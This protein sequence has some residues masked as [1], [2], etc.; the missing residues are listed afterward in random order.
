MGKKLENL[1]AFDR[2]LRDQMI[3]LETLRQALVSSG[4][5]WTPEQQAHLL[6]MQQAVAML[7]NTLN[8]V[9]AANR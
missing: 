6:A 5:V 3:K 8:A 2:N 1:E 4:K 9:V 7:T